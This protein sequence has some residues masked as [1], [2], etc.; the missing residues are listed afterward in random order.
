MEVN[1]QPIAGRLAAGP[2]NAGRLQ[3]TD[4]VAYKPAA[5]NEMI[6][7]FNV[8]NTGGPLINSTFL[9][10]FSPVGGGQLDEDPATSST[11]PALQ[12]GESAAVAATFVTSMPAGTLTLR[13]NDQR[14]SVYA[15]ST[16]T[17]P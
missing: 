15:S 3:I 2:D 4:V 6:V 16:L 5:L 14:Q 9:I 7:V 10:Y 17:K 8:K 11:V 1:G 12:P 13:S